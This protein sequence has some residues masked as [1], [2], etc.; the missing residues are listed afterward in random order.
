MIWFIGVMSI[1]FFLFFWAMIYTEKFKDREQQ[2]PRFM[3]RM[4][5]W[6]KKWNPRLDFLENLFMWTFAICLIIFVYLR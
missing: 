4:E 2:D 3:A 6:R 1:I 5:V